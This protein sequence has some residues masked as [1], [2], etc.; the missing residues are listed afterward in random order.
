MPADPLPLGPE[1]RMASTP[2]IVK[3]LLEQL[4][5]SVT[6]IIAEVNYHGACLLALLHQD[7]L[8][9]RRRQ[10]TGIG[11]GA[12]VAAERVAVVA[13]DKST[14]DFDSEVE[15]K[16]PTTIMPIWEGPN[17]GVDMERDDDEV[18][19][20]AERESLNTVYGSFK[21]ELE[22]IVEGVEVELGLLRNGLSGVSRVQVKPRLDVLA[23][24][25]KGARGGGGG[26]R[27][28]I[29]E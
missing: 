18:A 2:A 15:M 11:G 9:P 27:G 3:E 21:K 24:G 26:G 29:W 12:V 1:P 17:L 22:R 14:S 20:M 8:L 13:S 7:C 5:V 19:T 10:E 4:I 6:G 16:T 23:E 25:L 28:K